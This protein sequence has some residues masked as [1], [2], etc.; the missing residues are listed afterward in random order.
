MRLLNFV[1]IV[2]LVLA[3]GYVYQVKFESTLQAER[4]A[5]VRGE[6]RRERDRIAALRAEWSKLDT[7]A[8]VQGLAQRHLTLKPVEAAQFDGLERVPERAPDIVP[9]GTDDPIGAMIDTELLTGGLPAPDH[10]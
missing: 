8:R 3:A 10:R 9:P 2:V 5:K 7:P 4:V 6:I 1:V